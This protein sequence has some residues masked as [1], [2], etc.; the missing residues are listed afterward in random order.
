[1][2][3]QGTKADSRLPT[4]IDE[5]IAGYPRDVQ[6]HLQQ[7]RAM[8]KKAAPDAEEAIKYRIPTFVLGENLVHFAACKNH[9]GFYPTPSGIEAFKEDLSPYKSAKGSVQFPIERPMPLSLIKKIVSFRV[10]EA[11]AK[12][13]AKQRSR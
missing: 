6:A 13:T 8:I 5:Y 10:K 2:K 4:N 11:R 12:S 3:K 1:M 7:I 9:I